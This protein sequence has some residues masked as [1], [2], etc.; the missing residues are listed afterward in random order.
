MPKQIRYQLKRDLEQA[1]NSVLK[2]CS[3]LQ[4]VADYDRVHHADIGD[5]LDGVTA[6]LVE[7]VSLVEG[8]RDRL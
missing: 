5:A 4:R 2:G 3:Y 7:M 1:E 6:V 8:I